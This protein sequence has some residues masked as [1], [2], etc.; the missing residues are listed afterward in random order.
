M[1]NAEV[2]RSLTIAMYIWSVQGAVAAAAAGVN[3][4][5]G[6]GESSLPPVLVWPAPLW[7]AQCLKF[8]YAVF[9]SLKHCL[10]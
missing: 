4:D 1:S 10:E 5:A 3:T 9:F 6:Q 2:F 7:L 8:S